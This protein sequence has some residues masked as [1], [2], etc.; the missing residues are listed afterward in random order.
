MVLLQRQR[1]FVPD[2]EHNC[3]RR[4]WSQKLGRM[5]RHWGLGAVRPCRCEREA[6][7]HE[8]ETDPGV[9]TERCSEMAGFS[10]INTRGPSACVGLHHPRGRQGVGLCGQRSELQGCHCA[11]EAALVRPAVQGAVPTRVSAA[12]Q[13]L[14][15]SLFFFIQNFIKDCTFKLTRLIFLFL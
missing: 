13:V 10:A 2:S 11:G 15:T 1:N 4:L 3:A 5:H 14:L 12:Q 7:D 6:P 8:G 9:T